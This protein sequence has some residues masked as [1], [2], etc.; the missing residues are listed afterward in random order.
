MRNAPNC[1]LS[2]YGASI[3]IVSWLLTLALTVTSVQAVDTTWVLNSDGVWSNA[4][5]WD[6]GQPT[7]TAFNVF[8]DDGDSAVTVTLDASRSIGNLSLG[9]DDALVID[10]GFVFTFAGDVA[11]DG[12]ISLAASGNPTEFY[13]SSGNHVLSGSGTLRLGGRSTTASMGAAY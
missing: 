6:N 13:P 9:P 4:A 10:D 2:P 11:N 8:I 3:L 1:L 7:S 5:A 12:V